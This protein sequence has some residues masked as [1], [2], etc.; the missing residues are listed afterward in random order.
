MDAEFIVAIIQGWTLA[1][2]CD[3]SIAPTASPTFDALAS[4]GGCP[5]EWTHGGMSAY[6][7]G[8]MVS[9]IISTIPLRQVVYTCKESPYS[10]F[11]GQY[12]P[13]QYGGDQGWTLAG[14]CDGSI[15][16][17][18]SP[19]FDV[20]TSVG[21]C[22][23]EWTAGDIAGYEEGDTASV[24]IS[25]I[26]LRKIVYT[27]KAWPYS[28]F[29]GQFNP[30]ADGGD[31]GW[32]LTGSCGGS[33][34]PTASPVFVHLAGIPGGCPIAWSAATSDYEAGDVVSYT[35]SADPPRVLVYECRQ[36]PH[37]SYC[38]QGESFEP[39]STYGSM[40]WTLKGSC[41][42]T[43]A[44]TTSPIFYAGNC[45]YAKEVTMPNAATVP[46]AS[47]SS[48]D[49]T[50]TTTNGTIVCTRQIDTTTTVDTDVEIWSSNGGYEAGDVVRL[51]TK[52]FKCKNW[53]NSLWCVGTAYQ[54]TME[55][56]GTWRE[57]WS[58]DG[59]CT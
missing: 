5:E 17:T 57:A 18:A 32:T 21:G 23:E 38:N 27:C 41:E 19:T 12:H 4:F 13:T 1:G 35:I 2:S 10:G 50:C 24:T 20:L 47:G 52:R 15:G 49:C 45:T 59:M 26:P 14:S 46:C 28:G 44:P 33:I 37:S 48:T 56:T 58:E 36:W 30:R 3:G 51:A 29:C 53:P 40:G 54:P 6:E 42:G 31:Q 39:G 55:I 16:P 43:M 22:P 8:D 7:E 9:A 25:E 34:E 11:C